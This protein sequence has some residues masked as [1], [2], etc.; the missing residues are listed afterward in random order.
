MKISAAANYAIL[1]AGYMAK[2]QKEAMIRSHKI[3]Q[4][5]NIYAPYLLKVMNQ[6]VEANVLLSKRGP[7]GGY[8]LARS[9]RDI[10]MLEIIEA[11]DG[12]MTS[13]LSI[14]HYA[15]GEKFAAKA[16]LLFKKALDELRAVF[17]KT[18]LADIM[19]K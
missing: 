1:V 6:L 17:A 16:E 8:T 5:Y 11:A 15:K 18:K 4:E 2:H 10:T 3:A 12:P 9:P 19:K 14:A 13:T 7:R